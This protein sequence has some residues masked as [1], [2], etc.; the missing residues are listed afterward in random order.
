MISTSEFMAVNKSIL[1]LF[2]M[3]FMACCSLGFVGTLCCWVGESTK[4]MWSHF[5]HSN[6]RAY[7]PSAQA[8]F[9][10]FYLDCYQHLAKVEVSFINLDPNSE[11]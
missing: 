9:K 7:L 10:S 1:R 11:P 2:M 6:L 4:L 8:S 5:N 3:I